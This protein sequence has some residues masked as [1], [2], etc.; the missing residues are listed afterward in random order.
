MEI[1]SEPPITKTHTEKYSNLFSIKKK[2][3][4]N[5]KAELTRA[6]RPSC[7]RGSRGHQIKVEGGQG[8]GSVWVGAPVPLLPQLPIEEHGRKESAYLYTTPGPV[9]AVAPGQAAAD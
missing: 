3:E 9:T 7:T 2:W 4:R 5:E 1:G 8:G 6:R